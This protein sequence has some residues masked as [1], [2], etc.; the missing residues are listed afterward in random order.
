MKIVEDE[1][2]KGSEELITYFDLYSRENIFI[3][4][5]RVSRCPVE[6]LQLLHHSHNLNVS[7]TRMEI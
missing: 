4:L 3:Q 5:K 7:T 1:N 6:F 2:R